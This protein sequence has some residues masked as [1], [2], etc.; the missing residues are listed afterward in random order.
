MSQEEFYDLKL[1]CIL[2]LD[3]ASKKIDDISTEILE[4][5]ENLKI[6]K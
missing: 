5:I 1:M 6:E 2:I 4:I 3:K